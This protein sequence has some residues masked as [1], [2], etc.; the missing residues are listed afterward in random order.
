MGS[1]HPVENRRQARRYRTEH[2]AKIVLGPECM[3]SCM[4]KDISTGGARIALDEPTDLPDDFDLFIAAH[5]LQVHRAKL[6]W[7]RDGSLG[8]SFAQAPSESRALMQRLAPVRRSFE[9]EF[10]KLRVE[11]EREPADPQFVTRRISA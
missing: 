1:C 10:E 3:I 2:V 8:V 6:C 4:V 5:D 7:R 11:V 9:D